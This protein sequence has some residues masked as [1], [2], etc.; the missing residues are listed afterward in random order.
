MEASYVSSFVAEMLRLSETSISA[1]VLLVPS[2]IITRA[3]DT[4]VTI[5]SPPV[6]AIAPPAP[7]TDTTFV[8]RAL[9]ADNVADD[10]ESSTRPEPV[11]ISELPDWLDL[12]I[13]TPRA[14]APIA[15]A[16]LSLYMVARFCEL[17]VK[18]LPATSSEPES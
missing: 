14:A 13:C 3:F 18:S 2:P 4:C 12:V 5:A 1:P 16:S 6:A 11:I 9:V 15:N 17:I 7:A 10:F 8:S